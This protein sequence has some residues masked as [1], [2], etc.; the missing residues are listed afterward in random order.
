MDREEG[1][2]KNV[3]YKKASSRKALKLP[4]EN[5]STE[6]FRGTLSSHPVSRWKNLCFSFS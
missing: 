5:I 3:F 1:L 6:I 2:G 4:V